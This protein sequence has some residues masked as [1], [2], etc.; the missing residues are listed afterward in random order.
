MHQFFVI[1]ADIFQFIIFTVSIYQIIISLAGC[2]RKM[3]DKVDHP[4]QKSFAI[5]VAAHNE[6]KVIAPLLENLINLDY[7]KELYEIFVICDNCTDQTAQIVKQYNVCAMERFDAVNKGK[8]Y[9]MEWMLEKL[10]KRDRQHD[11]VVV[12]DADNLV[13]RNFLLEMN[14]NLVEG[15]RVI[16]SYLETKNPFDSWVSLSYAITYWFINRMWQEARH[17]WGMAATL[18]GTGMCF[19]TNLLKELGWNATSLTEDVEFTAKCISNE[20]YPTWA[21]NAIV[22]DEKP[23]TLMSSIRQRLRWMRGHTDCA[24][25]YMKPLI[26]KAIQTK[27]FALFDAAMYLFQP[28]RFLFVAAVWVMSYLQVATPLYSQFA[29]LKMV[30]DWAWFA[31]NT[32]LFLQFPLVMLMERRP[33]KAYLGL[34]LFPVFQFTWFPITLVG[35]FTSKNKTWNHTIHTRSIRLEDMKG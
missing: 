33:W 20:I 10:W 26:L 9:A 19:E 28:I 7:P 3:E 17:N 29:L 15:H 4:P 22:Y 8:G 6:E 34:I 18:S 12:F 25:R 31:L 35:L 11:A 21:K 27:R 23:I 30:P 2:R 32:A 14:N 24:R 16:Q 5:L 13:S 1:I